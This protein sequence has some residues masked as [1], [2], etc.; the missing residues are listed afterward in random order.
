MLGNVYGVAESCAKAYWCGMKVI[1]HLTEEEELRALPLLLR[2][3]PGMIL[4]N[5]TYILAE[6]A[7]SVLR[8]KG[9]RYSDRTFE[10]GT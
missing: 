1:I 9:I 10:E 4:P 7:L 8:T 5:R 2:H 6:Y 3:S